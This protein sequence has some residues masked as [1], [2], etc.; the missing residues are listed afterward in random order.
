[1]QYFQQYLFEKAAKKF[2]YACSSLGRLPLP[3]SQKKVK[4]RDVLKITHGG[5]SLLILGATTSETSY[6]GMKMAVDKVFTR[7]LLEKNGIP[8][9]PQKRLLGKKDLRNFLSIHKRILLK[10]RSSRAGKGIVG[11]LTEE[12]EAWNTFLHLK[13]SFPEILMER[14]IDGTE[15]RVLVVSGKVAAV[16]EYIPSAVTGN[17]RST[18][19]ALIQKVN[20]KRK[21]RSALKPIPVN[22]AL[23]LSLKASGMT[24][25][26]VPRKHEKVILHK[27]A[28]ISNGGTIANVTGEIHENNKKLAVRAASL[29]NLN[30]AGVDIL[31][32]NISQPI[33]KKTGV[34]IEVNG[35]PDL[36][37]HY[38]VSRGVS[39]NVAEAILKAYFENPRD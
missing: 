36:S 28:P 11:N 7:T 37:V 8:V 18:V 17:G 34:I 27:A 1:M 39:M 29:L 30:V 2:G 33:T 26:S 14:Q 31:A 5:R 3:S 22:Q 20:R 15:Y 9:A 32:S 35:G 4:E 19:R 21:K 13:K 24:L 6:L 25:N 38:G 12:K 23:T 16:A 10:P